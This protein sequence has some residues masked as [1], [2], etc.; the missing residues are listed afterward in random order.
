MYIRRELFMVETVA[1]GQM[2]V[3]QD[4]RVKMCMLDDISLRILWLGN[5]WG[6]F[7]L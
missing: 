6:A 4:I 3:V 5:E 1:W 2:L 7:L